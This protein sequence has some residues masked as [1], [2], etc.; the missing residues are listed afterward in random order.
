MRVGG[1]KALRE[2]GGRESVVV[3]PLKGEGEGGC[4]YAEGMRKG[5]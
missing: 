4:T 2:G 1:L 5:V 3:S